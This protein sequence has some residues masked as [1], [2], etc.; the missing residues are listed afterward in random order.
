MERP[1][2]RRHKVEQ[3]LVP[4]GNDEGGSFDE[5]EKKERSTHR[6]LFLANSR[7]ACLQRM[8]SLRSSSQRQSNIGRLCI[9][10]IVA[11]VGMLQLA[12]NVNI[13]FFPRRADANAFPLIATPLV[14]PR[15]VPGAT[16]MKEAS[17]TSRPRSMGFYFQNASTESFVGAER[18]DHL[19]RPKMTHTTVLVSKR[20][21]AKNS[22]DYK[23]GRR[24]KFESGDCKAQYEWQLK[25]YPACNSVH[26]QELGLV[27]T[28]RVKL[29]GGGYW[30]DVWRVKDYDEKQHVLKTIRYEHDFEDRNY[31]R[32]RRDALAMERLTKSKNIVDIYSFC[33]N[34]GIF[35]YAPGGDLE[36]MIWYA[37]EKWNSTEK[38][39]VSYQVAAGIGE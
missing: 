2:T 32:H 25:S 16:I 1:H 9:V 3:S 19:H 30:R 8:Q 10:F 38:L 15:N 37:D 34:S 27:K 21:A 14:I 11:V 31:D 28:G 20:A 36:D 24:D 12:R 33:G 4:A 23:H 6:L 18:L 35:E 29:L 22:R 13:E 39:I 7:V 26:E 17:Y 5:K